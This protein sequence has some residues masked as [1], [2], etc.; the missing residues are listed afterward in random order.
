M[1]EKVYAYDGKC[2]G[3]AEKAPG[4]L[5]AG[6]HQGQLLVTPA[7]DGIAIRAQRARP[8]RW[9]GGGVWNDAV[10]GAEIYQK[11]LPDC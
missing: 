11:R 2:D 4:E 7:L 9:R 5:A 8:R 1:D 10:R 6:E 3:G